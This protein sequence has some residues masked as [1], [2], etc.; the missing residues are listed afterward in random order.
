MISEISHEIIQIMNDPDIIEHVLYID[1]QNI[2]HLQHWL[3]TPPTTTLKKITLHVHLPDISS[4][5]LAIQHFIQITRN[6]IAH[7]TSAI[8]FELFFEMNFHQ[9]LY[10]YVYFG[11]CGKETLYY[12]FK[13]VLKK[14]PRLQRFEISHGPSYERFPNQNLCWVKK[15]RDCWVLDARGSKDLGTGCY[16]YKDWQMRDWERAGLLG[17]LGLLGRSGGGIILMSVR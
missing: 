1:S 3:A 15:R 13:N 4:G 16:G 10:N 2:N 12:D 6:S 7:F 8:T 14:L 17:E 11:K 9:G 5:P